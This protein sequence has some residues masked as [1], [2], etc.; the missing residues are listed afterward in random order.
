MSVEVDTLA[1]RGQDGAEVLPNRLRIFFIYSVPLYKSDIVYVHARPQCLF[2]SPYLHSPPS[3]LIF[4]HCAFSST[5]CYFRVVFAYPILC[6]RR[7]ITLRDD[8]FVVITHRAINRVLGLLRTLED[9]AALKHEIPVCV[10]RGFCYARL[11]IHSS[12]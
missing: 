4:L 6:F 8:N 12:T 11:L 10:G 7:G 5:C 3:C 1:R 2:T 9:L